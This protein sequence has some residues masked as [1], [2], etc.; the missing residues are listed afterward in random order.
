M[1]DTE[2]I[3]Y[4]KVKYMKAR[5]QKPGREKLTHAVIRFSYYKQSSIN[6][7]TISPDCDISKIFNIN[8]KATTELIQQR[9]IANHPKKG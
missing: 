5:E 1:Y 7:L 3:T 9:I 4:I 8:P 2:F 6:Y